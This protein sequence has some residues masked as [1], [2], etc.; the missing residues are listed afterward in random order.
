[1]LLA[2]LIPLLATSTLTGKNFLGK[3][4]YA[5]FLRLV[6]KV[7]PD[8][9]TRLHSSGEVKPFVVSGLISEKNF[10]HTY[11]QILAG[12]QYFLRFASIEVRLS[13]LLYE[14]IL[15]CLPDTIQLGEVTFKIGSPLTEGHPLAKSIS[16]EEL[17]NKHFSQNHVKGEIG[18][19]FFSP[20]AFRRSG[21]NFVVPLPSLFF[22]SCL[23][24]WN[25]YCHPHFDK[26]FIN[27]VE[28]SVHIS[29]FNLKTM[30]LS[31]RDHKEI[32]CLGQCY[33][34][35]FHPEPALRRLLNLLADFAFFCGTGH[36]TT[37][38]MGQTRRI[39]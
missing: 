35:I 26:D 31:F 27:L 33:Y 38:G 10:S 5:F 39:K 25:A 13:Q 20:T 8:L 12:E 2:V 7:D 4:A 3:E 15:P 24:N 9:S 19:E 28:E 36:K 14:H 30:L 21:H 37:M 23:N 6:G 32:G 29:R 17:V 22:R 1:M 11:P 34:T 16:L 18:L